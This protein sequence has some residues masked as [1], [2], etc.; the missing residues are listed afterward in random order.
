MFQRPAGDPREQ[1]HPHRTSELSCPPAA[2]APS[3][4]GTSETAS[5]ASTQGPLR[6]PCPQRRALALQMNI[7]LARE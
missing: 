5:N 6:G 7:E 2:P 3:R 4:L 1:P